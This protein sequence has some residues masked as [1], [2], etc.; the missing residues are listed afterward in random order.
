MIKKQSSGDHS[1]KTHTQTHAAPTDSA[2]QCNLMENEHNEM[3]SMKK[4]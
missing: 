4:I 1:R 2:T 3:Q